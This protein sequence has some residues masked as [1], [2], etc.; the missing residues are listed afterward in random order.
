MK[1]RLRL[2][3]VL[4]NLLALA[5]LTLPITAQGKGQVPFKGSFAGSGSTLEGHATHL[6]KFSGTVNILMFMPPNITGE[7]TWQA[8]N[9]DSISGI[10]KVTLTEMLAPNVWA[11][12]ST[13]TITGGTGHFEGASGVS[14]GPGIFDFNTFSFEAQFSGTISSVGSNK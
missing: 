10:V 12:V 9:G 14:G 2:T 7:F 13:G 1:S 5:L 3:C 4:R 6:G 11:F 8:A